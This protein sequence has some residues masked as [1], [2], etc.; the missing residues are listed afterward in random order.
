MTVPELDTEDEEAVTDR[1]RGRLVIAAA[2]AAVVAFLLLAYFGGALLASAT[3][4]NDAESKL[5]ATFGH[6]S[7]LSDVLTE[8]PARTYNPG[9]SDFNPKQGKTA[10]DDYLGKLN[11]ALAVNRDDQAALNAVDGRI[12]SRRWL[13]SIRNSDLERQHRR[14]QDALAALSDADQELHILKDQVTYLSTLFDA[15][16]EFQRATELIQAD[17]INGAIVA[18]DS[19][20]KKMQKALGLSRTGNLPP[21]FVN[22]TNN[23]RVLVG[24]MRDLLAA[25]KRRDST[26]AEQTVSRMDN[27]FQLLS[28]FNQAAYERF[29]DGLLKPFHDGY[30]SKLDKA[31][32]G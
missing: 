3:E 7:Q 1:G 2:A 30:L 18:S 13:T 21:P 6:R 24:D 15:L 16:I 23:L 4:K 32:S 29:E 27:D 28:S 25:I 10:F 8:D 20:D 9:S 31:E 14:I 22:F 26:S 19:S 12:Q 5:K 11:H 17:D